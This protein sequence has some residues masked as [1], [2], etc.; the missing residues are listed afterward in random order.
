MK[1]FS[2]YLSE[3]PDKI[4]KS[5]SK[6]ITDFVINHQCSLGDGV[7]CHQGLQDAEREFGDMWWWKD[8]E[9]VEWKDSRWS[10][11]SK[12]LQKTTFKTSNKAI[13]EL[14]EDIAD[15]TTNGHSL[16]KYKGYYIDPYLKSLKVSDNVIQKFGSWW[17][18]FIK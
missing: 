3:A 11:L 10:D 13:N 8:I 18:R 14:L 5:I 15:G 17:E 9:F 2:E 12:K 4:S 16:M 6:G 7:Q 1:L